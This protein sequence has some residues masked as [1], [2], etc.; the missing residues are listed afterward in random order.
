[1][2]WMLLMSALFP[3]GFMVGL[4]VATHLAAQLCQPRTVTGPARA[5]RLKRL[6]TTLSRGHRA[7]ASMDGWMVVWTPLVLWRWR[8]ED[9]TLILCGLMTVGVLMPLWYVER[10]LKSPRSSLQVT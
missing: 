9:A 6:G 8:L 5:W 2:D 3:A 1:M 4:V 10:E 7:D